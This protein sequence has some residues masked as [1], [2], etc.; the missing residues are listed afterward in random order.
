MQVL[1]EIQNNN[2]LYN[3]LDILS[4]DT[5]I[6]RIVGQKHLGRVDFSSFFFRFEHDLGLFDTV[7]VGKSGQDNADSILE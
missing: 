2:I 3:N 4:S 1:T 5:N 6:Q 7:N